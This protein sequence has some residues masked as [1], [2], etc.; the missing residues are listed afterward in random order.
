[1]AQKL[2]LK[3]EQKVGMMMSLSISKAFSAAFTISSCPACG[4]SK[5]PPKI[6]IFKEFFS[7][8][9]KILLKSRKIIPKKR[10]ENGTKNRN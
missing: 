4:G 7:I 3:G 2:S 8:L 10:I 9:N 6:A 5:D 1:M